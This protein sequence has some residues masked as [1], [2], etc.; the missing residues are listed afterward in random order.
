MATACYIDL[1][2][3]KR[4]VAASW[5]SIEEYPNPKTIWHSGIGFGDG[6]LEKYLN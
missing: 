3:P 2:S 1:L 6:P 4:P 5:T